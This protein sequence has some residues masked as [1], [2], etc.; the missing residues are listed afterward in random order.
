MFDTL[1]PTMKITPR[2]DCT[3]TAVPVTSSIGRMPIRANGTVNITVRGTTHDL[4]RATMM[5]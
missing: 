2:T 4:S 1:I 5:K 3:L